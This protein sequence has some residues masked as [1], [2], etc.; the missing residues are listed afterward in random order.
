MKNLMVVVCAVVFLMFGCGGGDIAGAS[1]ELKR[2]QDTG[3]SVYYVGRYDRLTEAERAMLDKVLVRMGLNFA[4]AQ[5]E[6]C[7]MWV[8]I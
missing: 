5:G 2:A 1:P 7:L 8:H 6:R 3:K 4:R